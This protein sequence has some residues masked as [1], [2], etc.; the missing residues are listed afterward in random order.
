MHNSATINLNIVHTAYGRNNKRIF[1]SSS[2]CIY[3]EYAQLD[4]DIARSRRRTQPHRTVSTVGRSCLANASTSPVAEIT[5]W[6]YGSLGIIIF[7]VRRGAGTM[8]KIKAPTAICHKVAMAANGGEIEI[9]GD[10]KQTRSFLCIDECLEGTLRMM[11]SGFAGPVNIGSDE[12]V[13]IDQLVDIIAGIAGK[14]IKKRHIDGPTG[15][16]AGIPIIGS[17]ARSLTGL[18]RLCS[19]RG[20]ARR[21]NGISG[22]LTRN[23]QSGARCPDHL[24]LKLRVGSR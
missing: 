11:R 15:A 1:Y 7:S 16:A 23:V 4:C 21:I 24:P 2:A 3:P 19:P 8:A 12:M 10:G 13:T 20:C 17:S 6:K 14:T 9:C 5:A 18:P 22:Q